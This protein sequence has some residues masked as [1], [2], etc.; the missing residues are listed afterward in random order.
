MKTTDG[1][2]VKWFASGSGDFK[3]GDVVTGKGTIKSVDHESYDKSPFKGRLMTTIG[4]GSFDIKRENDAGPALKLNDIIKLT[5][6]GRGDASKEVIGIVDTFN[7]KTKEGT[8]WSPEGMYK[9]FGNTSKYEVI[10][11]S[12]NKNDLTQYF[13]R[14][15]FD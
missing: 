9:I 10:G 8:M 13:P 6:F 4:R 5:V 3:R 2:L 12:A 15:N 11:T 14:N 1:K 7:K